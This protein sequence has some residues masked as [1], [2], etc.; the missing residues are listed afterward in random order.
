MKTVKIK[1]TPAEFTYIESEIDCLLRH[2]G[3]LC[4]SRRHARRFYQHEMW[5]NAKKGV[6]GSYESWIF[7]NPNMA[8]GLNKLYVVACGRSH[9]ALNVNGKPVAISKR[10]VTK[11]GVTTI[12]FSKKE[13]KHLI[14]VMDHLLK[15]FSKY[16]GYKGRK[17]TNP[18][19]ANAFGKVYYAL[20]GREHASLHPEHYNAV[21]Q[22]HIEGIKQYNSDSKMIAEFEAMLK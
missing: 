18:I 14:R 4:C 12:V 5:E 11:N 17:Y 7:S 22:Y 1:F 6:A 2:Y 8:A 15:E 10:P 21:V 9:Y 20:T 19:M 13:V 3:V 16:G